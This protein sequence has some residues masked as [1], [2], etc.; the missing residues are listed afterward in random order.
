[1]YTFAFAL[2]GYKTIL[3][4]SKM[5]KHFKKKDFFLKHRIVLQ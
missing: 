2:L 1:M 3:K 5:S 4:A